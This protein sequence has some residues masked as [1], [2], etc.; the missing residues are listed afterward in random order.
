MEGNIAT[1]REEIVMTP[2][3]KT[4]KEKL[5]SCGIDTDGLRIEQPETFGFTATV[6]SVKIFFNSEL[7]MEGFDEDTVD[8]ENLKH[9]LWEMMKTEERLEQKVE[10]KKNWND[11]TCEYCGVYSAAKPICNKCELDT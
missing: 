10:E 2:A 1:S 9:T 8:D 6:N 7:F 3:F 5:E 4:I 11:Y